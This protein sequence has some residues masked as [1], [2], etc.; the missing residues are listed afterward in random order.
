MTATIQVPRFPNIAE[1]RNISLETF[2]TGQ[3]CEAQFKLDGE[4]LMCFRDGRATKFVN[5]HGLTMTEADLPRLSSGVEG[6]FGARKV[7]LDGELVAKGGFY[8]TDSFLA[9]RANRDI[10][11]YCIF[12]LLEFEGQDL[13]GKPFIERWQLLKQVM[14]APTSRQLRHR[15]SSG[16]VTIVPSQRVKS[17]DEAREVFKLAVEQGF[18]GI[19]VKPHRSMFTDN[20]WLKV[21]ATYTDDL[22]L[23]GLR[24]T[25]NLR[26]TGIASSWLLETLDGKRKGHVGSGLDW[27]SREALTGFVVANKTGEDRENIYCKPILTLEIQHRGDLGDSLRSPSI[28][29]VRF[30]K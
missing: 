30:D 12:D 10:L 14:S 16:A 25:K 13:R 17:P 26:E 22:K 7:V 3:V 9:N 4:R 18:E 11:A 23:C 21:K 29:R 5:R 27:S 20:A 28:V 15:E 19:V 8:G 2:M 1:E 24:K 6:F